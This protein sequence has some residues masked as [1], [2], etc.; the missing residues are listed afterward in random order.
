MGWKIL[1]I[2][3]LLQCSASQ[4]EYSYVNQIGHTVHGIFHAGFKEADRRS[5]EPIRIVFAGDLMMD[6]S[7][8]KAIHK[9]GADFPFYQ[10]RKEVSKADY[11]VV[12]L[13]TSVS[14]ATEKDNNQLF[15]F[16]SDPWALAGV[17][18]AGFDMVS[19]ANNHV[20]D[21]KKRGFMDTIRSL[22]QY[23]LAYV[24]AGNNEEEA[25]AAKTLN[26]KGKTVKIAA[27]SRFLPTWE[28]IAQ[29][30]KYG[31]A[32]A[33]EPAKV[34]AAIRK[35]SAGADYLIV[36]MH[37]GVERS[38]KP[39]LWQRRLARK[40]ID[41][42]ADAVVGSHPHVLQGF[43]FYKSKPI[44]Y[45]IGNFLFPDYIRGT[46]ADTGLLQLTLING[47]VKMIFDPYRIQNNRIVKRDARYVNRQ[48]A[49]L[50]QLSYNVMMTGHSAEQVHRRP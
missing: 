33:Y 19:L 21:Y 22:N 17:K 39:E 35:E 1:A 37:W 50:E 42:G 26:L 49:Y 6:G 11:A 16:K 28:W 25:Y 3:M 46:R 10:I 38:S 36:F 14:T 4:N 27:F 18:H 9:R 32:G 15:N 7:V 41:A 30:G 34:L 24:G 31:V 2:A 13:E 23:G 45:S 48:L 20:L 40:M 12:N 43:E 44:A 5:H 29:P 8:K 47:Q